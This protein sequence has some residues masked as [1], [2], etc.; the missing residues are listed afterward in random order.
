M[1]KSAQR[2]GVAMAWGQSSW[3]NGST[4]ARRF[5]GAASLMLVV[6]LAAPA[7]W[8]ALPQGNAVT[9]PAALLRNALP[10]QAPDLQDL[11]HRLEATSDDL[12]AKR[13]PALAS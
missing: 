3:A 13:W 4:W 8:A 12:R 5:A 7:S 1:P 10:I 9:Y 6:L 11:Q 2:Q